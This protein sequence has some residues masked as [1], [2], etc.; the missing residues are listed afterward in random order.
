MS[1]VN[2]VPVEKPQNPIIETAVCISVAAVNLGVS[3]LIN[4]QILST[5]G[6]VVEV[7]QLL[8]EQPDYSLWGVDDQFIVNWTLQQLGLSKEINIV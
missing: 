4:A 6:S 2:I 8:L 5:D 1:V 3:A 7:K